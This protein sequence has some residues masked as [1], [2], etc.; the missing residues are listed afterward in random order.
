MLLQLIFYISIMITTLTFQSLFTFMN[1]VKCFFSMNSKIISQQWHFIDFFSSWIEMLLQ[2]ILCVSI[3]ITTLTFQSLFTF[4][5]CGHD[6][7]HTFQELV[8]QQSHFIEIFSSW[9]EFFKWFF[10]FPLWSK[11]WP[12]I[13]LISSWIEVLLFS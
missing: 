2:M 5:N 7:F 4:M 6:F 10:I 8:S 13:Y 1:E 9:I 11:H 3:M 12:F